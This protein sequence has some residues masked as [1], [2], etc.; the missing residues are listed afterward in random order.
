MFC[1]SSS[2]DPQVDL[3]LI[4]GVVEVLV[5]YASIVLRH[6][7]PQ[8]HFVKDSR[9]FPTVDWGKHSSLWRLFVPRIFLL[10]VVAGK[11]PGQY[12]KA[13]QSVEIRGTRCLR[14]LKRGKNFRLVWVFSPKKGAPSSYIRQ[15]TLEI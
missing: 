6:P 3:L 1:L 8:E 12:S 4:L 9:V 11:D 14:A 13:K 10:V 5:A 15:W 7:V 2:H